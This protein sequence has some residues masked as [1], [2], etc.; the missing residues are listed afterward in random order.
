VS[1]RSR[2][3]AGVARQLGHP[4]GILGRL[5]GSALNRGNVRVVHTAVDAARAATGATAADVG[6][7]GGLGLS[8]LVKRVG[9]S[10]TVHGVEIS[11]EM[12]DAA[13]RRHVS[14]IAEGRVVLHAGSLLALPF[15][16][17]SIDALITTNTVY[18][19]EDVGRVFAELARVLAP[20]GRAAVG[21]RDPDAMRAMP[22]APY[23][24]HVRDVD[25]LVARAGAAGLALSDHERVGEGRRAFHVLVF[26]PA[27]RPA[28]AG[29]TPPTGA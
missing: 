4:Q 16:D 24:F 12:L 2:F 13:R 11:E 15:P 9:P 28:P 23:G 27:P 19:V 17:A 20:D 6:F 22:V 14:A 10:G 29:G 7:G 3:F 1:L 21:I 25:D 18:F 5:V 26:S 8:L